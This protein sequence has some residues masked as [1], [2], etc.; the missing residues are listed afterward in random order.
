L[1]P[2]RGLVR[3]AGGFE[4]RVRPLSGTGY[5]DDALSVEQSKEVFAHFGLAVHASNVLEHAVLNAIF[6]VE[7]AANIRKFNSL[8]EWGQAYDKFFEKGFAQT[9]GKLVRRLS[10]LEVFSKDLVETLRICKDVRNNLVHH[11][12]R[13]AADAFYSEAGRSD[14]MSSYMNAV[15]LFE[16]ANDQVEDELY[17]LFK[18]NGID[19]D[20]LACR[21]EDGMRELIETKND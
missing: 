17:V 13:D 6:G 19:T 3:V 15:S 9:F 5:F 21:I 18:K 2:D 4:V 1:P 8:E 20:W 10:D 7:I 11:A 16:V 14:L 12:Q